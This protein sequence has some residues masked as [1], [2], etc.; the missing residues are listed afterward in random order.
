MTARSG[1]AHGCGG[2]FWA[3]DLVAGAGDVRD[4]MK[5]DAYTKIML[6]VV[7]GCLLYMVAKDLTLVPS[8]HA[9]EAAP[10]TAVNIVQVA[11]SPVVRP[12]DSNFETALPVR[13]L[14]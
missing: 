8:A 12:S 14:Q 6:T 4:L 7:A 1:W 13:V 3:L 5:I 2:N 9:Q 11:G 10:V